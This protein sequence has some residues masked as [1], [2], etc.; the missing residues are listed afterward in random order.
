MND[1]GSDFVLLE[2][3]HLDKEKLISSILQNWAIPIME[4]KLEIQIDELRINKHNV[5][6]LFSNFSKNIKTVSL[7]FIRFCVK[8]RSGEDVIKFQLKRNL[9]KKELIE[10]RSLNTEI[11]AE[12]ISEKQIMN[13]I[14]ENKIIEIEFQPKIKYKYEPDFDDRFSVF[15]TK[16]SDLDNS[17]FG[18]Q[19]IVM[20]MEQILWEEESNSFK[21]AKTRD[22]IYVLI[23]SR[24]K[25]F[26]ESFK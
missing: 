21:A 22:D 24:S 12:K 11:F 16:K 25:R 7:E 2:S 23:S 19:G 20:R 18:T 1:F 17:N 6:D 14:F 15:I 9:T 10:S 8:A 4:G 3:H 26:S 13:S 5:E